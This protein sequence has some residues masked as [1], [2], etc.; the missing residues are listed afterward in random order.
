MIDLLPNAM[1][2]QLLVREH[3]VSAWELIAEL[4]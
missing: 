3:C 2:P 1:R 4:M